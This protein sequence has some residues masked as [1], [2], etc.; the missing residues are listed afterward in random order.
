MPSEPIHLQ[1]YRLQD[2][3]AGSGRIQIKEERF[4]H[5]QPANNRLKGGGQK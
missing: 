3:Y 2:I 5:I 1:R 4:S